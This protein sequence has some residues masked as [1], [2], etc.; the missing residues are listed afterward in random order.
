MKTMKYHLL[1]LL[2]VNPT[3]HDFHQVNPMV[4]HRQTLLNQANQ[5]MLLAKPKR[6]PMIHKFQSVKCINGVAAPTMKNVNSVIPLAAGTGYHLENAGSKMTADTTIHPSALIVSKNSSVLMN[7]VHT[8][9][10]PKPTGGI[11]KKK[12]LKLLYIEKQ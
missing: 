5:T 10:F 12:P 8:S 9:T 11:L 2:Q 6:K 7:P 4:S 1:S 3:H